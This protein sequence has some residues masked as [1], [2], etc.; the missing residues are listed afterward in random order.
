MNVPDT[1]TH[2][3]ERESDGSWEDCTWCSG[4]EWYRL[5]YDASK[6]ATLAEAEAL[7][8]ASGEP[9][10]GGSNITDLR[11]GIRN[12]Y[13]K[14]MP[15]P[16]SGFS[17]LWRHLEPGTAA[18]IQGSMLAFGPDHRLSRWDKHFDGGHA[19]LIMRLDATD[20]VWWCDPLAPKTIGYK[21]EWVTKA[22]L[23]VFVGGY[24]GQHLVA[25]II[26]LFP[27]TPEVDPMWLTYVPGATAT[28]KAGSN[29]RKGDPKIAAPKCRTTSQ[30]EQVRIIGTVK[31]DIDPANG[32]NVW[33]GWW[34]DNHYDYTA[35]DNVSSVALPLSQGDV[36]K[37]VASATAPLNARIAAG[38]T[39]LGC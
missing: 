2:I 12:R 15:L 24:A 36:D 28:V 9:S 29:I 30:A 21:G 4:L 19:V 38:K 35:L 26:T 32:K 1:H 31:G 11:R 33:Y 27:Q 5:C 23:E 22:E 3:S 17:T 13:S 37:A 16:I 34:H 18:A 6:P 39:A 20:R 14:V 7:R 25:D 10:T 8:K